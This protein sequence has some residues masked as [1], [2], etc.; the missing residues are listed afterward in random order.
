MTLDEGWYLM[1]TGDL[2][3]ELARLRDPDADRSPSNALRLTIE[4]ALAYRDAGNV[5]D[6]DGR[7]LRLVLRVE[8]AGELGSLD[9]KRMLYEPDFHD[10][11]EWRRPDSKPVNVVPLRA[12][13]V[14]GE[15][16]G[17]WW[18]RPELRALEE[19]WRGTGTVA[20]MQVPGAYRGFVYKTVLSLRAADKEVTPD[21]VADSIARWLSSEEAEQ[22]RA[23]LKSESGSA[24]GQIAD[25]GEHRH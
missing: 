4:Q 7:T 13:G 19:E 1:S 3:R 16:T 22:V 2:E 12:P 6:A 21:A 11:P 23:A 8:D 10:R 25:E 14:A 15:P 24:S 9:A 17:P 5:P 20:G 18:E